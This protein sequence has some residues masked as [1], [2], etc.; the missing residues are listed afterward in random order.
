MKYSIVLAEVYIKKSP[1]KTPSNESWISCTKNIQRTLLL[2]RE[3]MFPVCSL[4]E[5]QRAA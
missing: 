5:K 1:H 3:F 2:W 4:R